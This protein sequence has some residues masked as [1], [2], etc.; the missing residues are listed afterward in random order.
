MVVGTYFTV[1]GT[2]PPH[3]AS[4]AHVY[5]SFHL[6]PGCHVHPFSL[7]MSSESLT[8]H[9]DPNLTL[10]AAYLFQMRDRASKPKDQ[11]DDQLSAVIVFCIHEDIWV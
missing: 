7:L 11:H 5:S 4:S 1:K 10:L 6:L 2:F 8:Q 9:R 3:D